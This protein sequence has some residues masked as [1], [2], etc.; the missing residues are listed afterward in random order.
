MHAGRT[1]FSQVIEAIHP[2]QFERCV[3][4]YQG[5]RKVRHFSCWDQFLCMAFA[6]LTYRESLRDIENCLSA[7]AAQLYRMGFRA[8]SVSRST[9]A[10]A[11][12]ARDW[13]IY[14]DLG[15]KLIAKARRLYGTEDHGLGLKE[16]VYVLDSS[17]V[18]LCLSLFRWA[19]F[20]TTKAAIKLH[21]L[22][23]LRGPIPSFVEVTDGK[24]HD[25]FIL[26][27]LLIEPGA[28]YVMDRGYMDFARLYHLHRARAYFVIRAKANLSFRRHRSL[29]VDRSSGLRSDHIGVF[30]GHYARKDYP[31]PLRRVRYHDPETGATLVFLTNHM[32]LDALT[33]C[34][35]YK[36]RWQVE[37]FF[38]WIKGH[39]RIKAFYGT[40]ANAVKT[41]VWIAIS[42]YVLIAILKKEL[43][44]PQSLHSILQI[45]SV[46]PFEKVPIHELLT[47]SLSNCENTNNPNQLL[48][49]DL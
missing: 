38:K 47:D 6:Q 28:F 27:S 39:L 11:N 46:N 12:E 19:H 5:D 24:F 18:D 30:R 20:R 25:V 4:R 45:L 40:S 16:M 48:L 33:V 21:T 17:T 7:R 22:L 29:S 1:V 32:S 34:Q 10:D 36:S 9:L 23:D 41:Q 13:R 26:D 43:G 15:Q 31:E 8:A 49:W 44:L 35:L 3:K 14:A 2:E 37:L 42:V